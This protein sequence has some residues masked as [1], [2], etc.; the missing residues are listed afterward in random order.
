LAALISGAAGKVLAS[1]CMRDSSPS[2]AYFRRISKKGFSTMKYERLL[3][4]TVIGR[5]TM[6]RFKYHS[7]KRYRKGILLASDNYLE[8]SATTILSG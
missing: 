1:A 7:L 8:R 4:A 5:M 2:V 3:I 6:T